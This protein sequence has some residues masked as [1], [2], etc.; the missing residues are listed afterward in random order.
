MKTNLLT[1]RN[2]IRGERQPI[3]IENAAAEHEGVKA[4][5]HTANTLKQTIRDTLTDNSDNTTVDMTD[6]E[7][8]QFHEKTLHFSLD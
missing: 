8:K 5:N 7:R 6:K 2:A 1:N 3:K 4:N